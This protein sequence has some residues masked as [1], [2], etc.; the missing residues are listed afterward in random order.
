M[1]VLN[2]LFSL[3]GTKPS[4]LSRAVKVFEVRPLGCW[5]GVPGQGHLRH[6]RMAVSPS[7]A[8]IWLLRPAEARS[9]GPPFSSN[10]QPQCPTPTAIH[11]ASLS[12]LPRGLR[13]S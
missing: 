12:H 3:K 5:L 10:I 7:R 1:A 4:S 13:S 9:Q 8:E 11:I 6:V 2:L